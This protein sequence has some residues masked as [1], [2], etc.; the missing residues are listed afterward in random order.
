MTNSRA[1]GCRGE[2]A[3]AKELGYYGINAIRGQQKYGSA[4]TPDVLHDLPAVHFEVKCNERMAVG[5]K[6]L[7][8]ALE[9]ALEDT[10]PDRM[11]CVVWK[12]SRGRWQATFLFTVYPKNLGPSEVPVTMDFEHFMYAR[13]YVRGEESVYVSPKQD[14]NPQ[15]LQQM[16][17]GTST[18]DS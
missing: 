5:S 11:A 9:Q 13:G 12:K 3:F 1:K 6:L 14:P 7:E 8:Q 17:V 10:A 16:M 2:V 18:E 4:L 15:W